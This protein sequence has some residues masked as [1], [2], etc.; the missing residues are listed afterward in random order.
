MSFIYDS[1]I[2][3]HE[4]S[5]RFQRLSLTISLE[6][7]ILFVFIP[8]SKGNKVRSI[9]VPS[10]S[11]STSGSRR[12]VKYMAAMT[13]KNLTFIALMTQVIQFSAVLYDFGVYKNKTGVGLE[14]YNN[15]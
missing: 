3:Q 4:K 10:P 2:L 6:M 11:I 7:E 15:T 1:M 5:I 8:Q 13:K 12:I 9:Q 14:G